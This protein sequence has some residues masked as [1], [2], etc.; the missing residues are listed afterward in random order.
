MRS[1]CL[2]GW[3]ATHLAEAGSDHST[4]VVGRTL[5]LVP[6][7]GDQSLVGVFAR[8]AIERSIAMS[9]DALDVILGSGG[10]SCKFPEIG[11]TYEGV[12]LKSGTKQA[13]DFKTKKPKFWE[14]GSPIIE[15]FFTLQT[16][17]SDPEVEDDDG[18]RVLYVS[19]KGMRTAVAKAFRAAGIGRGDAVV[20][21]TLKIQ[22]YADGE[23]A[24][25]GVSAPKLYR[26]KFTPPV[27]AAPSEVFDD[28]EYSEDPF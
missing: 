2:N 15:A 12:I 21:G 8:A 6:N 13:T 28:D 23:P 27:A 14:D 20:G 10:P 1:C 5:A 25:V 3:C 24:S 7:V 22:Y 19:S 18:T 4:I 16:A 11:A 17:L 26:A 9:E